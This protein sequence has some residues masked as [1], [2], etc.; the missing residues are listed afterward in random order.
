MLYPCNPLPSRFIITFIRGKVEEVVLIRNHISLRKTL[1]TRKHKTTSQLAPN[2]FFLSFFFVQVH[3]HIFSLIPRTSPHHSFM[4]TKQLL[5]ST[6]TS[7]LTK[8]MQ[9]PPIIYSNK[10]NRTRVGF[11]LVLLRRALYHSFAG[12]A[13]G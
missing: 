13:F 5:S 6:S 2:F 12:V 11:D 1:E 9:H 8:Y 4:Q 7:S 3:H 10:G